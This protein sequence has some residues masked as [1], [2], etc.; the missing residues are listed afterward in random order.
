[1]GR[2]FY[3]SEMTEGGLKRARGWGRAAAGLIAVN[4]SRGLYQQQ[5]RDGR[6]ALS[7]RT[8]TSQDKPG[9]SRVSRIPIFAMSSDGHQ[10]GLPIAVALG[11]LFCVQPALLLLIL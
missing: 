11:R 4:Q 2:L 5:V 3:G 8:R 1:M 10:G 9:T 7:I 6:L